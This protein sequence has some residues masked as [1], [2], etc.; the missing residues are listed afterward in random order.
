MAEQVDFTAQDLP[1]HWDIWSHD[2]EGYIKLNVTLL[3]KGDV[4]IS[5]RRTVKGSSWFS[6]RIPMTILISK[7]IEDIKKFLDKREKGSK[8]NILT[9]YTKKYDAGKKLEG[10]KILV[11]GITQ[12]ERPYIAIIEKDGAAS[13][14]LELKPPEF[15]LYTTKTKEGVSH[16]DMID[17]FR[18][19]CSNLPTALILTAANFSTRKGGSTTAMAA[20]SKPNNFSSEFI[21]TEDD[22]PY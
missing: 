7:W 18:T 17:W 14:T 3:S 9:G 15:E 16:V 11:V 19:W 4:S 22:I 12:E 2:N 21:T 13:P 20:P 8:L 1:P 6:V 5:I 10:Q